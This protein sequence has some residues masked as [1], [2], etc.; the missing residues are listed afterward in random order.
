MYANLTIIAAENRKIK[1]ASTHTLSAGKE[2]VLCLC[3]LR[4]AKAMFLKN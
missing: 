4:A 2:S 3:I 1:N